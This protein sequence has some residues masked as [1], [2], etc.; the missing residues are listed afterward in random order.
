M[1][2]INRTRK[3]VKMDIK[4]CKS[5]F[6]SASDFALRTCSFPHHP[7]GTCSITPDLFPGHPFHLHHLHHNDLFLNAS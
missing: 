4:V 3:W 6:L 1:R 7:H 5:V 2:G